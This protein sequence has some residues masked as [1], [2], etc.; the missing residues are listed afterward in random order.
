MK[1]ARLATLI[2]VASVV[3]TSVAAPIVMAAPE[4]NPS[5]KVAF[6][7]KGSSPKL[8]GGFGIEKVACEKSASS[9]EVLTATEARNVVVS[10]SH[11]IAVSNRGERETC[12]AKSTNAPNESSIVTTTLRGSLGLILPKPK[13]GSDVGLLLEP[14]EG[15]TFFIL[16]PDT[17]KGCFE[18]Q[19]VTGKI[20]GLI[21]PVGVLST[22]AKLTLAA[23]SG[24]QNIEEIDLSAGGLPVEP[25]L[26]SFGAEVAEEATEQLS[27]AAK[28]EVT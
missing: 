4:F 9:G 28:V 5:T 25:E 17:T 6:T 2:I 12:T 14:A 22:T 11:C 15:K 21:E 23:T 24:K 1:I 27:F 7:G 3:M 18:E 26:I 13:S 20:A 10:F 19:R 8:L 16:Q